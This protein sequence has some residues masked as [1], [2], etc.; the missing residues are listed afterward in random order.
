MTGR[1][2]ESIS[3]RPIG[4][5]RESGGASVQLEG[6]FLQALAHIA[7]GVQVSLCH[8]MDRLHEPICCDI[9]GVGEEF[10]SIEGRVG[11]YRLGRRTVLS[12]FVRIRSEDRFQSPL[13]Q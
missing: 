5:R 1:F 4:F 2:P 6:P 7:L 3:A 11:P 9:S 8:S 10:L 13:L 12:A